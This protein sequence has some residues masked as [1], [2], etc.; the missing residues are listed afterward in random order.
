M[1]TD[2]LEKAADG[3]EES[4]DQQG[5]SRRGGGP[6]HFFSRQ[7]VIAPV[8]HDDLSRLFL[9][10]THLLG[11]AVA[12]VES[13]SGSE[14]NRNV[15][16]RALVAQFRKCCWAMRR[17]AVAD[18]SNE[19]LRT[20]IDETAFSCALLADGKKLHRARVASIAS[21]LTEF[22]VLQSAGSR[23]RDSILLFLREIHLADT[24]F[25]GRHI[26]KRSLDDPFTAVAAAILDA[27]EA[28]VN[29]LPI[30]L[31]EQ[32]KDSP[33]VDPEFQLRESELSEG[34]RK[35][36]GFF[37]EF[38]FDISGDR[39]PLDRWPELWKII[40]TVFVAKQ[41]AASDATPSD[42]DPNGTC[43]Y[44][45]TWQ[46]IYAMKELRDC[47]TAP[48]QTGTDADINSHI[49]DRIK[50]RVEALFGITRRRKASER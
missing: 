27:V 4:T 26:T 25:E 24:R 7:W 32:V 47:I 13:Q 33:I 40:S 8:E 50:Q 17:L 42:A 15:A 23:L 22:P 12:L 34:Q 36:L 20:L 49:F 35:A 31:G 14:V 18:Q 21:G 30:W 5:R 46:Q 2:N 6:L 3:G 10:S 16:A 37:R 1:G 41:D 28:T 45:A 44:I 19:L 9:S 38:H 29:Q 43:W 48:S 39:L 11:R